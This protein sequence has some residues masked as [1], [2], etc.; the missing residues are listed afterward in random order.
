[1]A[2][3]QARTVSVMAEDPLWYKDAVI[4]EL[5]IKSFFDSNND[6]IGDIPGVIQKLDYLQELGVSAIW[7]LPFYP[8][9]LL[10]DGYDIA[11][12]YNI[13]A[14]YGTL[15][16]FRRLL[17]EAHRRGIRIITEL[18]INH[19]SDQHK[20]FQ[21]A[22]R[23]KP[24]SVHRD[25]YVW[26]DKPEKYEDARII[27]TDSEASNW[28]WDPVAGQYYWHR[29]YHHQ[30]DLNFDNPRVCE[31]IFTVLDFWFEMGV[32]GMRLDAVPYLFER[33]DTNCENLPE[34]HAF[35]K[36]LRS[37][38]DEKFPG[39]MLLAEANQWPEDAA[40]YFGDGDECHMCFHFPIMPRLFMALR[41][42]DR[43]PVIDMLEQSMN[44]PENC[45]WGMFLRNH[46]ELTLEM[47]TDQ[48]RDYMYRA[49]AQDP[50][51]RINVGIRRRLAP[52]LDNNR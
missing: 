7:L 35:L 44:I 42:E 41:T 21:R 20:W 31:E 11:D 6:G 45:Q 34:T 24:G 18:V 5:H 33:E 3:K 40:A 38:M 23:A 16:D 27:F 1:M 25:Y 39:R 22:R 46:D 4:Y 17:R 14:H 51:A 30:P 15:S 2:K 29:F 36:A 52:L 8:S 12:Y 49:Y 26:T 13:N 37:R 50:R 32:D 10:D 28:S 48:E 9:P 43:F 47:V 19:T